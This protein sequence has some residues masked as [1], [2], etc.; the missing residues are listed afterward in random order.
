MAEKG[1]R[2]QQAMRQAM[3][4]Q[5]DYSGAEL[6]VLQSKVYQYVEV[7]DLVS[8]LAEKSTSGLKQ[9]LQQS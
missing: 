5:K 7:V 9:I 2:G 6:L 8:K 4:G 1:Q 3:S